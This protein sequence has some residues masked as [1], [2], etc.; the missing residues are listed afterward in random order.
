MKNRAI[1]KKYINTCNGISLLGGSNFSGVKIF[2]AGRGRNFQKIRRISNYFFTFS[3]PE[4]GVREDLAPE[5]KNA[6]AEQEN[7]AIQITVKNFRRENVSSDIQH[8]E[9]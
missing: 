4:G 3:D 6:T 8:I 2:L 5:P 1:Y 7:N 9:V